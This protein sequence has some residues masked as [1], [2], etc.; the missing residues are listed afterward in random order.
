M[1]DFNTLT[2]MMES[3]VV[4]LVFLIVLVVCLRVLP[5]MGFDGFSRK[6]LAVCVAVLSAMG[7]L[8]FRPGRAP[9]GAS[10]PWPEYFILLPYAA[11]GLTLLLLPLL[12]FLFWCLERFKEHFRRERKPSQHPKE[13]SAYP[14]PEPSVVKG[15]R[16]SNP[17]ACGDRKN[18]QRPDRED[19]IVSGK[20]RFRQ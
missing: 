15:E 7:L 6:V 13:W 2:W 11:L 16:G 14:N 1:N 3:P 10:E 9:E 19:Q 4:L 17:R 20:R 12:F 8:M 5:E 18:A